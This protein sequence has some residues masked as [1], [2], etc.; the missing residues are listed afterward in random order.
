MC[1][2]VHRHSLPLRNA[3]DRYAL[4]VYTIHCVRTTY[5]CAQATYTKAVF[6]PDR[7]QVEKEVVPIRRR[8]SRQ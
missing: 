7:L 3:L 4:E 6:V 5:I 2:V 1:V 8:V